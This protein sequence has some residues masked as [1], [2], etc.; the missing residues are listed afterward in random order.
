MKQDLR[1][2]LDEAHASFYLLKGGEAK[3]LR[4]WEITPDA[5]VIDCP[6]GA[7]LW[8]TVLGYIPTLDG[9]AIYEI[10]GRLE[11]KRTR[12]Q[13]DNTIRVVVDPASV[14]RVQRRL[15]PRFHFAPPIEVSIVPEERGR[16]LVGKIDNISG[17]GLRV[18]T[19]EA[20]SPEQVYTFQFEIELDDAIHAYALPGQ[21]LYEIPTETG[22]A[23]GVKFGRPEDFEKQ[24]G[25]VPIESIDGTVDLLELVNRLHVRYGN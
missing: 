7:P 6:R 23:Y 8:K 24:G 10:E 20:L 25:E 9:D 1:E 2:I 4:L 5:L 14:K 13:M 12:E 19:R 11:P 22:L 15:F 21:V 16:T 18:E 3:R 17:G